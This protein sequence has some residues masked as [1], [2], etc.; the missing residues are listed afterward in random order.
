[1]ALQDKLDYMIASKKS[2]NLPQA[3]S[4]RK[5]MQ[6]SGRMFGK[7]I[8]INEISKI[9]GYPELE[10]AIRTFFHDMKFPGTGHHHRVNRRNLP[11]LSNPN[12]GIRYY[13]KAVHDFT[14]NIW[15]H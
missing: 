5:S 2:M 14:L 8:L 13:I 10:L 7:A 6:L 9:F 15:Q 12:V 11:R 4:S 3:E 1:M